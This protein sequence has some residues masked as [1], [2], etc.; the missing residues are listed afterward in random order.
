VDTGGSAGWAV[1][2]LLLV[3][4]VDYE[5]KGV[6]FRIFADN[7]MRRRLRAN[8]AREE[9]TF[10]IFD[11]RAGAVDRHTVTYPGGTR[12]TTVDR[13]SSFDPI[14]K[15]N[16]D[17]SGTGAATRYRFKDGQRGVMSITDVYAGVQAIGRDDPGTL[18]ELS[19]F[20]HAWHGGPI[21]VNSFDDGRVEGPPAAPGGPPT[22]ITLVGGARDPDDKDPRAP[23]DFSPPNMS[24]AQLAE[25]RAAYHTDGFNW[26]WGCSFPRTIHEILHRLQRHRSYRE[27]GLADGDRFVFTNF[28]AEHVRVLESVLGTTFPAPRRVELTFGEFKRFF[29]LVTE[30]S[31]NHHL[32]VATQ[33][34]TFGG[35]MGTYSEYDSG[36]LPLMHVH[37]GFGRHFRFYRNYLGFSFDPEGRNYGAFQ[38]GFTCP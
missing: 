31:Y 24:A 26:S 21:L 20:S 5:F 13:P 17:R 10:H 2:Q 22:V 3:A 1:R 6:N 37:R 34:T 29:C 35:V 14:G 28:R 33:R 11:F 16:Y 4:G 32:A 7:R 38:P 18:L 19:F 9:L 12:T 8:R 36:S 15:A 30:A 27:R 25:L 23:K